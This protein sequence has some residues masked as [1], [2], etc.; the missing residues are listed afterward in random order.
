MKKICLAL[1]VA[2]LFFNNHTYAQKGNIQY[3]LKWGEKQRRRA[4]ESFQHYAGHDENGH[5][6]VNSQALAFNTKTYFVK[7]D[8][9]LNEV[10]EEEFKVK[11][12]G[13][14]CAIQKLLLLNGQ[15]TAISSVKNKETN[16]LDLVAHKVNKNTFE[17]D[18]SHYKILSRIESIPLLSSNYDFIINFSPDSSK[19]AIT[20]IFP[21]NSSKNVVY[22]VKMFNSNFDEIW[23]KNIAFS[24]YSENIVLRNIKVNKKGDYYV[25]TEDA[26][27]ESDKN[28]YRLVKIL[29]KGVDKNITDIGED[30]ER[31]Y[32]LQLQLDHE[33]NIICSGYFS[34][35]NARDVDGIYYLKF[36]RED[37]EI[38]EKWLPDLIRKMYPDNL[39]S[40]N[41]IELKDYYLDNVLVLDDS[42][43][44]LTCESYYS[45]VYYKSLNQKIINHKF[46]NFMGPP[47]S[48]LSSNDVD[49]YHHFEDILIVKLS[50]KGDFLWG[51]KIAKD[52]RLKYVSSYNAFV[53]KNDVYL[54]YNGT[55]ANI[56]LKEGEKAKAAGGYN[57]L[58]TLLVRVDENANVEKSVLFEKDEVKLYYQPIKGHQLDENRRFIY[59]M[60]GRK[61]CF[62]LLELINSGNENLGQ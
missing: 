51:K 19:V 6:I 34:N 23:Q 50:S 2:L 35:S 61:E 8:N 38:I 24:E 46:R 3:D 48:T 5:Y 52:Q 22:D 25:L 57:G 29:E 18:E 16:G 60:K 9:N 1:F 47:P 37:N 14:K 62:L 53:N 42:S 20:T 13:K 4:E 11:V 28:N 17:V 40:E 21:G 49:E 10:K 36:D 55:K 30:D 54:L 56:N 43:V 39:K 32:D 15:L 12:N 33:G 59:T 44:M 26:S 41:T 58:A 27:D 45:N 31:F 7:L